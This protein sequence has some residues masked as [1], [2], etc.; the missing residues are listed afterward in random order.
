MGL[1]PRIPAILG[2]RPLSESSEAAAPPGRRGR[3]GL[4]ALDVRIAG[5]GRGAAWQR[6]RL[7]E[8]LEALA[9]QGGHHELGF[10]SLDAYARE[11]L[12]RT[13]R[14]AADS[15]A[16]ARRL[17][18]LPAIREAV[19]TEGLGWSAA[20]L[21]ARHADA[22]SEEALLARARRSNVRQLRD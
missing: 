5:L 4:E 9:R 2:V 20:G 6:L 1:M 15:R 22:E 21:L 14:W 11:R 17:A 8:G 16:L 19:R 3:E 10:S 7:G 18:G 12:E 13:G